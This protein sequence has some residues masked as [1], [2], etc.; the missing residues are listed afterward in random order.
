LLKDGL[1]DAYNEWIF[2]AA[3]NLPAFQTW[4]NTHS[5]DYSRFINFQKGRVFKLPEG[6]YYQVSAAK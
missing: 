4:T 3:S 6:Q 1:F 5:D 2:G